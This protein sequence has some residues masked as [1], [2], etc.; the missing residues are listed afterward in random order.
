VKNTFLPFLNYEDGAATTKGGTEIIIEKMNELGQ[1]QSQ[2]INDVKG[3]VT[4][5]NEKAED[6]ETRLTEAKALGQKAVDLATEVKQI[7]NTKGIGGRGQQKSFGEQVEEKLI[8]NK[9]NLPLSVGKKFSFDID[10]KT[11]GNLSS[12]GS[13]TGSYFVPPT[14]LPGVTLQPYNQTHLRDVLN[15]GQTDSNLIRYV[16][17][18]GGQGGPAMTSEGATKPQMDRA[19][20]IYDAPVRKLATYLRVPEEMI[21]DI[22]Y[23]T[24]FLTNVGTQE[25]LAVEDTQILYGDGTGQ[26]LSGIAT[27]GNFTAYAADAGGGA[28]SGVVAAPNDYDVLTSA[29]KQMRV[30]KR[31]PTVH[32]VSPV[33]YWKMVS[34]KDTTNNYILQGGGNGIVPVT[35]GGVPVMQMNQIA[36]GDFITLDKNAVQIMFRENINVRFYEQD[37]DNAIK[38]LVTIVIEER[39]A[40]VISYITGIIKGTFAAAITD[41][42]S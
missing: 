11:V 4:K 7:V 17:D 16:R 30:L 22:P 38:N 10:T 14:I 12:A 34:T 21:T 9:D 5:L 2:A 13:L 42:T 24:S 26:N 27:S 20:Q 39:L 41:L 29:V 8:A 32:L 36:A 40:L 19:L 1:K 15:V 25:M 6:H 18:N 28:A 3:Q 37:Q 31:V 35:A 23:L 33:D